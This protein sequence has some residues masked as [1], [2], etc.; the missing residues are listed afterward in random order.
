M[1][2]LLQILKFRA[3]VESIFSRVSLSRHR[4]HFDTFRGSDP[5]NLTIT[6]GDLVCSEDRLGNRCSCCTPL[7]GQG[8]R[9]PFR[10]KSWRRPS[11]H[12]DFQKD[13]PLDLSGP[14]LSIPQREW[15][16]Y[17]LVRRGACWRGAGG[18]TIEGQDEIEGD[19]GIMHF[20]SPFPVAVESFA[21]PSLA[22]SSTRQQS[23]Q[24]RRE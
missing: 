17:S 7:Q 16:D 22:W 10:C 9:S 1:A 5:A 13:T 2:F 15:R 3:I 8:T 12:Q 23:P 19:H 11:S 4:L 18:C 21:F 6:D 20:E 14:I 24:S